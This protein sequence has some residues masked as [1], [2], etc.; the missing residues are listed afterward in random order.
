MDI[1]IATVGLALVIWHTVARRH[2]P[3]PPPAR[4]DAGSLADQASLTDQIA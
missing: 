3:V 1:F 2:A 4:G